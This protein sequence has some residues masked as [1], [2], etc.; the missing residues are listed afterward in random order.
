MIKA[1][2]VAR[3]EE[4]RNSS[5][6]QVGK[7]HG[8]PRRR[9]EGSI[10]LK[11]VVCVRVDRI[12]LAQGRLLSTRQWTLGYHERRIN[13]FLDEL[14]DY[15]LLKMAYAPWRKLDMVSINL[16]T[17]SNPCINKYAFNL[18]FCYCIASYGFAAF[19]CPWIFVDASMTKMFMLFEV[20]FPRNGTRLW[21]QL[22]AF[23][24]A[25]IYP[26]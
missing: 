24:V 2:H 21:I 16:S 4:K 8:R 7:Q 20:H 22:A 25:N 18:F 19:F 14:I 6:T 11:A 10:K 15:Q 13:I 26:T 23:P 5:K 9:W 3:M 1:R 17:S 12:Q